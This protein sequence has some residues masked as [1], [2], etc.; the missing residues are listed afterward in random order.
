LGEELLFWG[1]GLLAA[2]L[3]LVVI[4]V[5]I[6]SG[7]L[8]S[9]V[10]AG[11][12]LGGL[13]CLFRYG[14]TWGLAGLGGMLILGP[15]VFTFALKIWP[16]TPLGRRMLGDKPAEQVEA[17]RLA[18][19]KE[20]EKLLALVGAEGVVRTDLRPLGVIEI[21]GKRYDA[22]S[23]VSFVKTGTRVRVTVVESNQVR[24]RPVA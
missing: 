18:A 22:I 14:T 3:L 16:N 24:V 10:S 11:C 5:F 12:A 1:L 20:R 23:D 19:L 4:E 9:L 8:I 17:E 13:Y 21:D 6:P 15:M 7:G 2:S